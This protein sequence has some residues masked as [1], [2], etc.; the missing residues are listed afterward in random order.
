MHSGMANTF[1]SIQFY[2]TQTEFTINSSQ[3]FEI[4]GSDEFEYYSFGQ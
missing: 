1:H 4:G 2:P 3:N